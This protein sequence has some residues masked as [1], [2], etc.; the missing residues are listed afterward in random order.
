MCGPSIIEFQLDC[1][2]TCVPTEATN[3]DDELY[4]FRDDQ[5]AFL[6]YKSAYFKKVVGNVDNKEMD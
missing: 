5:P 2:H 4:I 3:T 1:D 6:Q